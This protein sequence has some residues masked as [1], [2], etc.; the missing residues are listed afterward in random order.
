MTARISEAEP[1]RVLV[2][3]NTDELERLERYAQ[4]QSAALRR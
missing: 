2:E 4:S 1:G 3:D